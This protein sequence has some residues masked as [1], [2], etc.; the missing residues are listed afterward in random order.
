MKLDKAPA[1]HSP[2]RSPDRYPLGE[3]RAAPRISGSRSVAPSSVAPIEDQGVGRL[4]KDTIVNRW[5]TDGKY[6]EGDREV[7]LPTNGPFTNSASV[8]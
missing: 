3:R 1:P 7:G 6:I 4:S 5:K 8:L 2:R